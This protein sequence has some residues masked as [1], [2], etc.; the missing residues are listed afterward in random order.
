MER[1]N[2]LTQKSLNFDWNIFYERFGFRC[3]HKKWVF[4]ARS[5]GKPQNLRFLSKIPR[6]D[7]QELIPV[8][9][10]YCVVV[11]VPSSH[12]RLHPHDHIFPASLAI[13]RPGG[14]PEK[15]S[16]WGSYLYISSPG[17]IYYIWYAD[18][19][20]ISLYHIQFLIFQMNLSWTFFDQEV[21][22]GRKRSGAPSTCQVGGIRGEFQR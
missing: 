6:C 15:T 18:I 5:N 4:V 2:Q 1:P 21:P 13:W 20:S 11:R 19:I 10:V 12:P 8:T 9:C 3:P 14:P 7:C 17:F 22:H 16:L